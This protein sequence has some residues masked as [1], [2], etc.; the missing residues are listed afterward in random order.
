MPSPF[1]ILNHTGILFL[2]AHDLYV[3]INFWL[4]NCYSVENFLT[5][6]QQIEL[7][8]ILF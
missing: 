6:K 4:N 7:L 1:C 5:P 3:H 8:L 2:E